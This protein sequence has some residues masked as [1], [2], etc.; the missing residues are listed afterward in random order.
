[1]P[2]INACKVDW[3]YSVCM[4]QIITVDKE[5]PVEVPV[6]VI[7]Y[8]DRVVEVPIEVEKIVE[9]EKI[10][11]NDRIEY[12]DKVVYQD[13]VGMPPAQVHEAS[14]FKDLTCGAVRAV[15]IPFERVV[16]EN[17][18]RRKCH[19]VHT[20][21]LVYGIHCSNRFFVWLQWCA[22]YRASGLALPTCILPNTCVT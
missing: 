15:E 3:L 12:R 16:K 9:I 8:Y 20:S 4:R 13:R 14:S 22:H 19:S 2:L 6:E 18:V 11:W 10:V 7:Q 17:V 5:I 21:D 1:M